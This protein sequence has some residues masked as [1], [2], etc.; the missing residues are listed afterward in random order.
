[1]A[2]SGEVTFSKDEILTFLSAVDAELKKKIKIILIG[3]A[4]AILAFG[5]QRVSSDID[6]FNSIEGL[7]GAIKKAIKKT[8]LKIGFTRSGVSFAPDHFEKRLNP[9]TEGNFKFLDVWIPEPHDFVMMKTTRLITRDLEDIV[10]VHKKH[11]LDADRLLNLYTKEMSHYVGSEEQF[12]ANYLY[13][14]EKLFG[15]KTY[16]AHKA[17]IK[18]RGLKSDD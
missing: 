13:I 8:G 1:V 11:P 18:N 16:K 6:T 12:E 4:A 10:E 9:Y 17:K 2:D 5:H 3:G 7:E 14:I 15:Y